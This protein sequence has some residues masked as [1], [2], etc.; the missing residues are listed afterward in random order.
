MEDLQEQLKGLARQGEQ[1]LRG[2]HRIGMPFHATSGNVYRGLNALILLS[3]RNHKDL[4][5][6]T[7]NDL[8]VT[9]TSL[10]Q[11]EG[12]T[13]FHNPKATEPIAYTVYSL[14][15]T[16][17]LEGLKKPTQFRPL[18]ERAPDLWSWFIL[19]G[20]GA[21]PEELADL[22]QRYGVGSRGGAA[23]TRQDPSEELTAISLAVAA[24]YRSH[25]VLEVYHPQGAKGRSGD[26]RY[27]ALVEEI[28]GLF[29]AARM[30]FAYKPSGRKATWVKIIRDNPNILRAAAMDAQLLV[31]ALDNNVIDALAAQ[32]M[33]P[34]A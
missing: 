14:S 10:V 8:E 17:G 6:V 1:L 19:A 32:E 30:E 22:I 34:E 20:A 9:G 12:V 23:E 3:Q 21:W 11:P 31:D 13:L 4:G 25:A 15:D 26:P 7:Q 18:A 16:Q 33:G 5:Y 29:L 2:P 28:A 24:H 27:E